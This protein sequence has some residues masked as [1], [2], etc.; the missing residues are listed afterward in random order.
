MNSLTVVPSGGNFS[1]Q[2]I[3]QNNFNS[4]SAGV[5]IHNYDYEIVD[6]NGCLAFTSGTIEVL[7]IPSIDVTITNASCGQENGSIEATVNGGTGPYQKYWSNGEIT[8]N[9]I[10]L[11]PNNYYYN[12]TDINNCKAIKVA[13][14]GVGEVGLTGA[15]VSNSCYG[16]A[17]GSIDLNVSGSSGP[18]SYFWSNGAGVQDI[19]N[20][21]AGQ[22][23]VFVTDD[24]GCTSTKSFNVLEPNFFTSSMSVVSPVTC[25]SPTGSITALINGG[26]LPY[27]FSWQN[28]LGTEVSTLQNPTGLVADNYSLS[29]TDNNSCVYQA[30]VSVSD[31]STTVITV[32]SITNVSCS[33][34]G[35]VDVLVSSQNTITDTLWNNGATSEDLTNV[36]TGQYSLQ[37]TDDLGCISNLLVLVEGV[38]PEAIEICMVS[39]DTNTNTNLVIWQKPV[40]TDIDYFI[41][42]RETSVANQFLVVDSI[43]YEEESVFTDP[44]AYPK[45][46]SWRY[47]LATVNTCGVESD[48]SDFHKTMHITVS[49]GLGGNY[50]I[51]WDEYEGF[52][53]STY[54]LYRHTTANGWEE[55]QSL[56]LSSTSFTD[57]PPSEDGLDYMVEITPPSVCQSTKVQDHNSS[58]SNN[59][60][61]AAD[62]SGGEPDT[63]GINENNSLNIIVSPNPSTDKFNVRLSDSN[64]EHTIN[65][66]DLSGKL[67]QTFKS[68][69][70]QF[71]ID[72]TSYESGIYILE[73]K[74]EQFVSKTQVV[75]Q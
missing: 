52:S 55:I 49:P 25:G 75:K 13:T 69:D 65:V 72:M 4:G 16:E 36:V 62:G 67:I 29:V 44:I 28:S 10:E 3:S 56:P 23:E 21:L 1:N 70:T 34:N 48:L 58:R 61:S 51:N 27:T 12:I 22:Y 73:V 39:V 31:P 60:S 66:Y 33:Q 7:P 54:V 11:A 35:S 74:N 18:Y 43:D 2:F 59:T 47:K 9:I 20:L 68:T 6:G 41:I 37:L 17:N 32:N 50:N 19:D 71:S 45:L 26:T 57:I 8:D 30:N 5:G 24:N 40:T 15:V 42:Y 46:R 63:D 53:Y 64:S 38:K 14:V